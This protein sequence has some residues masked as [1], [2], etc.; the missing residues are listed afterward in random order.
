MKYNIFRLLFVFSITLIFTIA[1]SKY[2]YNTPLS[3]PLG[4]IIGYI[5]YG[6]IFNKV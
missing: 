3:I 2:I 1:F 6:F 5:L 4:L